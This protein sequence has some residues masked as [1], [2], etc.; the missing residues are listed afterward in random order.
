MGNKQSQPHKLFLF[1]NFLHDIR[2]TNENSFIPKSS[3][4]KTCQLEIKIRLHF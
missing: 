4:V 2:I 3:V 1:L